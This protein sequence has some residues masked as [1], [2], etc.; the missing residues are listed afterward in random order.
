ML[1]K[2]QMFD[3][4]AEGIIAQGGPSVSV[5]SDTVHFSACVY[6]SANG[7]K[8]GVGQLIPDELYV[9]EME[10]LSVAGI[11]RKKSLATLELRNVLLCKDGDEKF[12]F[13]SEL[14]S[15]HDLAADATISSYSPYYDTTN[16]F[17]CW[18]SLML[19]TAELHGLD[20]SVLDKVP[21]S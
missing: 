7:R 2:Q 14:Q 5:V 10:G 20:A 15:R 8:C 16:F 21:Q 12:P 18:K 13:C 4:V 3:K 9:P 11:F 1:T 17:K 19:R 6:R